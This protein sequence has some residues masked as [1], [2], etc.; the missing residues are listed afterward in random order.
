[1]SSFIPSFLVRK[2]PRW[3]TSMQ[4]D[5]N[6]F[7]DTL[8][9]GRQSSSLDAKIAYVPH[10]D[11]SETE[12]EYTL[13]AELPG[14]SEKDIELTISKDA[15]TLR[16]EKT[17]KSESQSGN[18]WYSERS[19]GSFSRTLPFPTKVDPER[20]EATFKDGILSVHAAKCD[21]VQ[22]ETKKISIKTAI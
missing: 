15:L 12:K 11:F 7:F 4:R 18:T 8:V 22:K 3:V 16:G 14:L 5:L 13:T 17:N 6:E 9:S 10:I 2:D 21:Q 19:Y 1:M 20:V